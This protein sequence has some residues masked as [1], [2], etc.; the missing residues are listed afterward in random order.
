MNFYIPNFSVLLP[1]PYGED[2]FVLVF[3]SQTFFA[4]FAGYSTREK[5]ADY[6]ELLPTSKI[7]W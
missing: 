1:Q 7:A 4:V 5:S 3:S 2:L 6:Y